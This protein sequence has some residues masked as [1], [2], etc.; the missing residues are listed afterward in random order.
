MASDKPNP[1][2]LLGAIRADAAEVLADQYAD[3]TAHD[4]AEGFRR[5]DTWITEGG[6]LPLD[7]VEN[8]PDY[9]PDTD[10]PAQATP[11]EGGDTR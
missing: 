7:W 1:N 9:Q 8:Q 5:L 6:H 3:E 4:L 2:G 11:T 10:Q